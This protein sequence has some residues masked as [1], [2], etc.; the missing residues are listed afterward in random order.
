[1]KKYYHYPAFFI[2]IG[3]TFIATALFCFYGEKWFLALPGAFL[4]FLFFLERPKEVL[5][6][7]V[8][9]ATI[10][11][12]FGVEVGVETDAIGIRGILNLLVLLGGLIFIAY[13]KVNLKKIQIIIPAAILVLSSL[14]SMPLSLDLL[15][16]LRQILRFCEAFI[17]YIL[18][19][20]IFRRKE[21]FGSMLM[22]IALSLAPAA[23]IAIWQHINNFGI[24][25]GLYSRA[26][27]TFRD[28][29][30][31]AYYI[32]VCVSVIFVLL[33][34]KNSFLGK[35]FLWFIL[36]LSL[37]ALY[38]SFSRMAW[39]AMFLM[40]FIFLILR[41]NK[42][43]AV[44]LTLFFVFL[45]FTPSFFERLAVL[46]NTARNRVS[47]D[48]IWRVSHWKLMIPFIKEM[49]LFGRG[50]GS[51]L[52][53]TYKT[54]G[55]EI[56]PHNDYIKLAV[57]V[58]LVG[59][60]AYLW[61]LFVL[62]RSGLWVYRHAK[63]SL[64]KTFSASFIALMISWFVVSMLVDIVLSEVAFQF[65]MIL[66]ALIASAESILVKEVSYEGVAGSMH[67]R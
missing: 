46:F 66:G 56:F 42:I 13:K 3:L 60:T 67:K 9:S 22:A 52:V 34:H 47:P 51:S 38:F 61:M 65:I 30:H 49:P 1:M 33:S 24:Q 37:P 39:L 20:E 48:Y 54:Y 58:G 11:M 57:E 15:F 45:I 32:V 63:D 19:F 4:F 59:L 21:E 18:V 7:F 23:I 8:F 53:S 5:L 10:L 6:L 41:P 55:L 16:T 25:F 50:L 36:C 28:P 35:F 31:F 14:I 40:T 44:F 27:S 17:L 2:A 29:N 12:S 64:F 43:A 62:F 26:L